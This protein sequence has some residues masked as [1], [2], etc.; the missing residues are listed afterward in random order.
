MT[1][2]PHDS[3]SF[4]ASDPAA[5]ALVADLQI[6]MERRGIPTRAQTQLLAKLAPMHREVVKR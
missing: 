5:D 2:L 3:E 6:A 1:A 4:P